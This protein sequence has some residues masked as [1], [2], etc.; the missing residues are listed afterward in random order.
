MLTVATVLLGLTLL[1]TGGTALVHGASQAALK[2]G[3]SPMVI[4]LTIVGF[5]TSTPELIVSMVAATQGESEI[6]FG[7]VIGSNIC[8][9]GLVL[10]LAA[11]LAPLKI[12]GQLVRR[13]LPLLLLGSAAIAVMAL[14]DFLFST[15]ARIS[16]VESII[17]LLLFAG[18]F[19]MIA[20]GIRE[21][22]QETVGLRSDIEHSHIVS[23][24]TPSKYWW[25]TL[26]IGFALLFIGGKV[27][28]DGSVALADM[29]GMSTTFIG[30]FVIA[31]G[32]SLPELVTS[33]VAAL[34]GESDLADRRTW[35]CRSTRTESAVL[36]ATT[37]TRTC[38]DNAC[39][40]SS[41]KLPAA[42][43]PS[44]LSGYEVVI[45]ATCS[46]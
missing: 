1:L 28:V 30:L 43:D 41:T 3:W 11:L 37:V 42:S 26:A 40:K 4:G 2:L 29:L 36:A 31:V 15:T 45:R 17:L 24:E 33:A 8:N 22:K 19:Y 13:D 18:F 5:G 25:L 39:A 21:T 16:A 35:I 38:S 10:G 32:T 34:R 23:S 9:I 44:C 7:N 6:A 46:I 12:H 14:D 20:I 27:T